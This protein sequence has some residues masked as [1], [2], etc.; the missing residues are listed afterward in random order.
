MPHPA[1]TSSLPRGSRVAVIG[2]DI[3]GLASAYLLARY[4]RVALFESAAYAGGH[5]NT[6]DVTFDDHMDP[7]DTRLPGGQRPHLPEADRAVRRARRPVASERH[8]HLGL[9][10]RRPSRMIRHELNTV[11]AQRRNL[12][13]PT[14]IGMLRDIVRF[15]SGAEHNLEIAMQT[16]VSMGELLAA[17]S[18]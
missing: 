16:R 4:H 3:S 1:L 14:F 15:N 18:T 2:V 11:F 12:F 5:T 17:G 8:E 13:S 7:V 9:A 10:R 6:V